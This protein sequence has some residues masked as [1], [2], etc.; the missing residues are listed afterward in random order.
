MPPLCINGRCYQLSA[1]HA[2]GWWTV[3]AL[4]LVLDI[5]LSARSPYLDAALFELGI[6]LSGRRRYRLKRFDIYQPI[7]EEAS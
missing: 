1:S 5:S 7:I 3:S 4:D 2:R 6:R